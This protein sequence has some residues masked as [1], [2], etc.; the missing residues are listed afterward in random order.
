MTARIARAARASSAPLALGLLAAWLLVAVAP[1][2]RAVWASRADAAGTALAGLH[3]LCLVA[4][5]AAC[6][7]RGARPFGRRDA[8][9]AWLPLA[10]VPLCY[11]ELPRV[12]AGLTVRPDLPAPLHDAAVVAWERAL[13]AALPGASPVLALSAWLPARAASELF[14]L[15]YLAYYPLIYVPPAWLW[16]CA[17][18]RTRAGDAPAARA[19]RA[20]FDGSTGAVLLAFV[21]CYVVFA[22]WPV[23]GPWYSWPAPATVPDG[24][25]RGVVLGILHAGSSRGTAFPSSHVAVSVAQ[26][27]ALCAAAAR[28][29]APRLAPPAALATLLLATGAVYGGFHWGVDVL[30]GAAV[31]VAAAALAV[32]AARRPGGAGGRDRPGPRRVG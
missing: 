15:G 27:L 28:A 21:A 23:A 24:P 14:H 12:A 8:L 13:F 7:T 4:A 18:R 30:A 32:P 31:G 3:L 20:A 10:A 17:V 5:L 19:A 6:T 9:A 16:W 29:T 1:L 25:V 22:C 2:A 26:S 11:A